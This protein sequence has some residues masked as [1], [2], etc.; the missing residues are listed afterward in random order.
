MAAVTINREI[1]LFSAAINYAR[2]E[3]D[4]NIPNNVQ[5]MLLKTSE[6][7]VRSLTLTEGRLLIQ[8]AEKQ[9]RSPILVQ[10]IRLALNTGCRKNELMKLE[11]RRVDL[12]NNF[13]LL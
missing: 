3:W 12:K 5:G 1:G 11:R 13:I 6:G 10:L 7:R 4:W 8:E 9:T 2:K